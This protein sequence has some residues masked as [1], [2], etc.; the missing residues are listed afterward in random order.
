MY[1]RHCLINIAIW[2]FKVRPIRI[3]EGPSLPHYQFSL[4]PGESSQEG[5][6]TEIGE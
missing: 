2:L 3:C 4:R 5:G 6:V 1:K